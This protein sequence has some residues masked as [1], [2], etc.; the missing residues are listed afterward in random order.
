M[1][2]L[3]ITSTA[4]SIK[5]AF[6]DY[7]TILNLS[8]GI[9][10]KRAVLAFEKNGSIRVIMAYTAEWRV[11]TDGG[12]NSLIVDSVNGNVPST[13]DELFTMLSALKE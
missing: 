6:N 1:A 13:N 11:S 2:N 10:D 5:V 9:Y 3:V 7:S 8:N 12:D 4:N